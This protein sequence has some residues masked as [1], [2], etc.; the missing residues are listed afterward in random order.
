MQMPAYFCCR[1]GD[2]AP[3]FAFD[4]VATQ[5]PGC[6]TALFCSLCNLCYEYVAL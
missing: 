1:S 5:T 3:A 2:T 4:E 6:A